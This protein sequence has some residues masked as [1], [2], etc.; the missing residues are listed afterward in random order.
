MK[1]SP[2]A[3]ETRVKKMSQELDKCLDGMRF[4]GPN[5]RLHVLETWDVEIRHL[6]EKGVAMVDE[7]GP[8]KVLR[9]I[10]RTNGVH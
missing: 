7:S 9:G 1:Q 8:Q 4:V 10:T 2:E 3:P 6:L 5:G